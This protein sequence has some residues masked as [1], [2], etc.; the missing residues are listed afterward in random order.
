MMMRGDKMRKS[1][2]LL[3]AVLLSGCAIEDS[4]VVHESYHLSNNESQIRQDEIVYR[5]ID[6]LDLAKVLQTRYENNESITYFESDKTMDID[7]L[8]D[9]LTHINPFDIKLEYETKT[10][11]D[12]NA[13]MK[14]QHKIT[15]INLDA[16][17][18]DAL[19]F[20]KQNIDQMITKDMNTQE[21][22][23]AI[24]DYLITHVTYDRQQLKTKDHTSNV[25]SAYGALFE[26]KAVCSGYAR[27]FM[28]YAKL[29]DIPSLY[30]TSEV[31]D[32]AW[33]YVYDGT[34]WVYVDVTWDDQDNGMISTDYLN[35]TSHE[36]YKN[37]LHKL[38]AQ[39]PEQFYI[40]LGQK[41]Y[42]K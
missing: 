7:I 37:G 1:M 39:E 3:C 4:M 15:F 18:E 26:K 23:Q 36:F 32:H 41:F 13:Q 27:A 34:A 19:M 6:E 35:K 5:V 31:L 40:Q 28:I 8:C 29:L 11:E 30:V 25:F 33:N 20:A 2:F 14:T 10:Y 24:H 38:D 16:F 17:Y 9:Y 42:G 21:K 12:K 22:L